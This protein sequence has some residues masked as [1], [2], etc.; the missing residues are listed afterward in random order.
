MGQG[1][2]CFYTLRKPREVGNASNNTERPRQSVEP[3]AQHPPPYES[4]VQRDETDD[5]TMEG[6]QHL[7]ANAVDSSEQGSNGAQEPLVALNDNGGETLPGYADV[8]LEFG[9]P[10]M[11]IMSPN[12]LAGAPFPNG[13][14]D[15]MGIEGLGPDIS[16]DLDPL[17]WGILD[18][19]L[20]AF[21]GDNNTETTTDESPCQEPV[22][23]EIS[24]SGLDHNADHS[25]EGD[26]A[27]SEPV[28]P[29][30]ISMM[31]ISPLETH[32]RQI[33]KYLGRSCPG[34]RAWDHWMTVDNMTLFIREYFSFFHQHTPLL[35]LPSWNVA[36]SSTRLIFSVVLMG[37][38]YHG[39]L[40]IRRS[41]A[42]MLCRVARSFA[43]MSDPGTEARTPVQLETI[44]A[45][46]ITT[47]MEAFY[48]PTKRQHPA[49]DL[50]MLLARAREAGL[51]EC[52][53]S[54][55]DPWNMKWEDW[56]AR[57]C[58]IR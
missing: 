4:T 17:D 43:W 8:N 37:A 26:G 48:L 51:F 36:T 38:M 33:L 53:S 34:S 10:G 28:L 52:V 55:P 12:S 13:S 47:V 24:T 39:D 11:V 19:S 31:Q 25:P 46:Y 40:E 2:L 56:S 14:A 7:A 54:R 5:F 29:I 45:V 58:R 32:R 35:H 3:P 9:M 16:F 20:I 57:E 1:N 27:A 6:D 21:H 22:H 23:T 44:Q 49:V 18:T 42:R 41:E 30:G 50:K 15:M